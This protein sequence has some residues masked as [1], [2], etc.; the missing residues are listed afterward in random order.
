MTTRA[1]V[2]SFGEISDFPRDFPSETR[3]DPG[4]ED[5]ASRSTQAK[6]A[7]GFRTLRSARRLLE[8][9]LSFREDTT[10]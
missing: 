10:C 8:E 4:G 1:Q 2:I 5:M 6:T 7:E 9:T 3:H